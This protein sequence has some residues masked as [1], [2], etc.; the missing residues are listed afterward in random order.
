[1]AADDTSVSMNCSKSA[2]LSIGRRQPGGRQAL[3]HLAAAGRQPGVVPLPVRARRRQRQ[4]VRDVAGQRVDDGDRLLR[5]ADADVHV[6]AEDLEP[7]GHPLHVVD[8]LGVAGVGADRLL[9]ASGE[10]GWRARADHASRP[11]A[12]AASRSSASVRLEVGPGLGHGLADAGDDL[13][14]ALEQLVLGLRVLAAGV[15]LAELREDLARP[16][17]PARRSST[18]DQLELHLDAEARPGRAV[19]VDL[20]AGGY[21]SPRSVPALDAQ[22]N[23]PGGEPGRAPAGGAV[24]PRWAHAAGRGDPARGACA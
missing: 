17:W 24:R 6:D 4:E 22:P 14:G 18:V 3:E 7:P 16:R 2:Q 9:A 15:A 1:M 11:R 10:N 5:R 23:R 19:E 13:D 20:H 8:Q 12:S 21:R